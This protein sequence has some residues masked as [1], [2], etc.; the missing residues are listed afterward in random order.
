MCILCENSD[1]NWKVCKVDFS[2]LPGRCVNC[3]EIEHTFSKP[4]PGRKHKNEFI[5]YTIKCSE[6]VTMASQE[7]PK[8]ISFN[9]PSGEHV[10]VLIRYPE[11][12]EILQGRYSSV[13]IG[14][15]VDVYNVSTFSS[16]S[17]EEGVRTG[18]I[19]KEWTISF[20]IWKWV[21]IYYAFK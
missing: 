21:C 6:P 20:V 2:Q 7:T 4:A 8:G 12:G 5:V 11:S 14:H 16:V 15:D 13:F 3:L 17:H 1:K 19:A 18:Y 9:C 10:E